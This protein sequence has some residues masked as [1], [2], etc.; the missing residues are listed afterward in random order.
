AGQIAVLSRTVLARILRLDRRTGIS[1]KEDLTAPPQ[2]CRKDTIRTHRNPE[3]AKRWPLGENGWGRRKPRPSLF[4]NG[5]SLKGEVYFQGE[6]SL[7]M[8]SGI[9]H[10]E[11]GDRHER[12]EAHDGWSR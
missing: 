9:D 1:A 4:Q 7:K 8:G 5:M 3:T 10:R 11:H 2:T 6:M 12:S